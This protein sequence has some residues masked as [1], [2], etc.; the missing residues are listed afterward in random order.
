MSLAL[1]YIRIHCGDLLVPTSCT[2]EAISVF[3]ADELYYNIT[4]NYGV[5]IFTLLGSQLL[6][7]GLAGLMRAFC[8]FP[9]Y[10]VY[11]NLIPTVNLFDALH[12]DKDVGAQKKRL[13]LFWIVFVCIMCWEFVPEFIAPTLTGISIFCLAKRDS[14][15][16]TRIFGG[17]SWFS[18]SLYARVSC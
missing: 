3:A 13:R 17:T 7:Y 2:A 5:A 6:G 10:I 4:P 1:A 12:R 16:V 15:W 9:T 11:P 18:G 14:A 8:V